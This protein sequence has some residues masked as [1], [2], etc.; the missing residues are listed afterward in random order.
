[1]EG[2]EQIRL[3]SFF[4]KLGVRRA[5]L[6]SLNVLFDQFY[7]QLNFKQLDELYDLFRQEDADGSKTF[8]EPQI[9]AVF[10]A[11]AISCDSLQQRHF[12]TEF[13]KPGSSKVVEFNRIKIAYEDWMV[14]NNKP[15]KPQ[16]RPLK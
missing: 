9:L 3:K 2:S 7:K 12:F 1:M 11:H 4:E 8:S 10:K 13:A 16:K 15:K 5:E 14:T 6:Y